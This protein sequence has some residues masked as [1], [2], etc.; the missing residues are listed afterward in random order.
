MA[1]YPYTLKTGALKAFLEKIPEVG[2]PDKIV[3]RYIYSLGFKS[4]NDRPIVKILQFL[5]FIDASGAP[6][7][8]YKQYRNRSIS[9][10]VLGEA[11]RE[12]YADLFKVYPDA[13]TRDNETLRNFFS[14]HTGLGSRAINSVVETFKV[15]CAQSSFTPSDARTTAGRV[16]REPEPQEDEQRES[17]AHKIEVALSEGRSVRIIMPKDVSSKEIEKIKAVIDALGK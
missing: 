14:T 6:S 8:R 13:N 16:H 11:V 7:E 4:T 1:N 3:N 5:K 15:L 9:A 12:A 10:S 2:V 17:T